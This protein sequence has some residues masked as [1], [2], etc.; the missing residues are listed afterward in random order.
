MNTLFGNVALTP[1]EGR[2]LDA[3]LFDRLTHAPEADHAA[4]Q[5]LRQELEPTHNPALGY[6]VERFTAPGYVPGWQKDA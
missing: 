2:K 6:D 4:I 1:D 3:Y 5:R